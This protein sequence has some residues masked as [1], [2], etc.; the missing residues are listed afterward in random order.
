MDRRTYRHTNRWTDGQTDRQMDKWT[1]RQ[2][3]THFSVGLDKCHV[4]RI[5]CFCLGWTKVAF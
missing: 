2:M 1:D 3:D 4:G 5:S